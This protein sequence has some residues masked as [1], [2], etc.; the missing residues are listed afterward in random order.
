MS[1]LALDAS[2]PGPVDPDLL[3]GALLYSVAHDLRSPLLTLS[4]AGELIAESLGDRLRNEPS[5]GP[6]AL[7]ALEHGARDLERMLQALTVV[8]RARRRPLEARR[9]P[10]RLLLGGHVVISD[11]GDLGSRLVG[12]DPIAVREIIDAVCGDAP[13]EIHVSLLNTFAVVRLPLHESLAEVR[14]SPLAALAHSLQQHAGTLVE[15]LAGAQVILER[16]AGAIEITD[17]GV[18]LWLPRVD[19]P[20]EGQAGA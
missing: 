3:V 16:C 7:D 18:R 19:A 12:V 14:G 10:L 9:A 8:S 1:Q 13:A 2:P 5:S 4:L 20:V 15:T 17:E 6:V 11:A